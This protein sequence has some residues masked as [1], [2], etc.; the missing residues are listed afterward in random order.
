MFD[1]FNWLIIVK[2][3]VEIVYKDI[4]KS[5]YNVLLTN[6]TNQSKDSDEI[7][8]KIDETLQHYEYIKYMN[9]QVPSDLSVNQMADLISM[10]HQKERERHIRYLFITESR[11][12]K[13]RIKKA[14][15][16]A[17]FQKYLQERPERVF[18][19]F[20]EHGDLSYNLWGNAVLPRINPRCISRLRTETKLRNASLFGQKLIIDLDYDDHMSLNECRIQVRHIVMAMVNN[21]CYNDPYDIYFTNCDPS[22]TT[23]T[24][25]EKYYDTT[26]FAQLDLNEHFLQKSYLDV[27]D[28]DR[29]VYLSPNAG[30][31]MKTYNHD[32]IYIVGGFLDK[33]SLNKPVSHLKAL[34]E[35][36][37]I[38][39]FFKFFKLNVFLP[40]IRQVRLPLD[41]HVM[42]GSGSSKHL[43]IMHMI[44]IMNSLKDGNDWKTAL[45]KNIPKRKLKDSEVIFKE[46]E[47]KRVAYMKRK[48]SIDKDNFNLN[49]IKKQFL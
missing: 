39:I 27:F 6:G 24:S 10:R 21:M 17:E 7:Q 26:P 9:G 28:K 18:G 22:K 40:G 23:M 19:I 45:H 1:I 11:K 44:D 3:S 13:D 36:R 16:T 38:S 41:E 48:L 20:D 37:N 2:F 4:D 49:K 32:D 33:S 46:E 25:L 8:A 30:E 29:L 43:C 14:A 42:W 31:S 35:G 12:M 34:R 5:K 47:Q 15:K